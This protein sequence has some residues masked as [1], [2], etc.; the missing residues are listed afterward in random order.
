MFF[1]VKF[2]TEFISTIKYAKNVDLK[3][4]ESLEIAKKK[5]GFFDILNFIFFEI[6]EKVKKS[7]KMLKKIPK[8]NI[9]DNIQL[10]QKDLLPCGK[11]I[12][13]VHYFG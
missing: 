9:I 1:K 5:N 6:Y 12:V 13:K 4:I 3:G 10:A 11:K 8:K 2:I 7:F